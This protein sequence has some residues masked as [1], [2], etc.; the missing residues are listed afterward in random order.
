MAS[1]SRGWGCGQVPAWHTA[2]AGRGGADCR[3]RSICR[4]SPVT[5]GPAA[6]HRCAGCRCAIGA[7]QQWSQLRRWG[8]ATSVDV[9]SVHRSRAALTQRRQV[10]RGRGVLGQ[11]LCRAVTFS[12]LPSDRDHCQSPTTGDTAQAPHP[13]RTADKVWKTIVGTVRRGAP[14]PRLKALV[15]ASLEHRVV[16]VGCP[17]DRLCWTSQLDRGVADRAYT[18]GA[19]SPVDRPCLTAQA[20]RSVAGSS[21][22][23]RGVLLPSGHAGT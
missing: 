23:Q 15:H 7:G 5:R 3:R 11:S 20:G 14:R 9:R 12:E 4:R 17:V 1:M 6:G 16:R 8:G 19:T 2:T 10:A 22:A 18:A 13:L 21:T